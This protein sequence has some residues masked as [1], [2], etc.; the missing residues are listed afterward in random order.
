MNGVAVTSAVDASDASGGR[1]IN[2]THDGWQRVGDAGGWRQAGNTG[3]TVLCWVV[4]GVCGV[5]LDASRCGPWSEN[6]AQWGGVARRFFACCV[7]SSRRSFSAL[8][9][10]R[11]R[12]Q[13]RSRGRINAKV[14]LRV[15]LDMFGRSGDGAVPT[16][17][18]T[19]A[20]GAKRRPCTSTPRQPQVLLYLAKLGQACQASKA[21]AKEQR[22]EECTKYSLQA[23]CLDD[24]ETPSPSALKKQKAKKPDVLLAVK[25]AILNSNLG[26]RDL[27]CLYKV[28]TKSKIFGNLRQCNYSDG[29][30]LSCNE[31][32][33][34]KMN[35]KKGGT[36]Y[37]FN[38]EDA[39][40]AP[41]DL[42]VIG[43]LPLVWQGTLGRR[44][45]GVLTVRDYV[46]RGCLFKTRVESVATDT[47][48]R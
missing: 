20:S 19:S 31:D 24:P 44:G 11:W 2:V 34:S 30:K 15:T 35:A 42:W 22:K 46:R 8:S 27:Y 47:R 10:E 45:E 28:V 13:E 29:A 6:A 38:W 14:E 39:R 36:L 9:A 43:T 48:E 41:V 18:Q 21:V 3:G 7:T 16:V 1:G 32:T 26:N 17:G 25:Q 4:V 33:R 23:Y 5:G 12:A 37:C 40:Q